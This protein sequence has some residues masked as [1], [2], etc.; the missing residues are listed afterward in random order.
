MKMAMRW[1][2][3]CQENQETYHAEVKEYQRT[4]NEHSYEYQ[5]ADFKNARLEDTCVNDNGTNNTSNHIY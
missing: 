2:L 5:N 1:I 3:E 4:W